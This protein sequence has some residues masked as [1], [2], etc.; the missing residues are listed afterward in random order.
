MLKYR[1]LLRYL[2]LVEIEKSPPPAA[3]QEKAPAFSPEKITI[4]TWRKRPVKRNWKTPNAFS[5]AS[6]RKPRK[7]TG[8]VPERHHQQLRSPY[9]L[10]PAGTKEDFEIEM[11]G[12][13]E[14][15]GALLEEKDG[16]IRVNSIVPGSASWRQKELAADDIILKV[17]QG[18]GEPEDVVDVRLR[19]A[20]K[21]I[22]G[23]RGTEVRLTVKKPD[24]RIVVIPIIRDVVIIEETYARSA[25]LTG[26]NQQAFGYIFLP[27]FYRNFK[28]A[29]ERNCFD[30][31]KQELLKLKS[32]KVAGVILDLRNN[33]GGSLE[34]VVEISGL[35]I[36]RGPSSRCETA[37]TAAPFW[38]ITTRPWYTTVSWWSS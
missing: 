14:G 37:P 32:E 28:K 10:F 26:K 38:K 16:Y 31:M 23:P 34:D 3:G 17:A 15:I 2:E 25:L 35:F 21:L 12:T 30:D 36:S 1:T 8:G 29:G 7:Q 9:R 5:S 13:L 6:A 27:K 18:A 33:G 24:G 20:V 4:R 22:R 11:S 19:D